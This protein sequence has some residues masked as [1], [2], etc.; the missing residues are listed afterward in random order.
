MQFEP[1]YKTIAACDNHFQRHV[2]AI[3]EF[4]DNSI[5]AC[6][7]LGIRQERTV[8]GEVQIALFLEPGHN[9]KRAFLVVADNGIGMNEG[10]IREFAKYANDHPVRGMNQVGRGAI[11]RFGVGATQASAYLGDRYR[12]VSKTLDDNNVYEF[13]SDAD[14]M[15]KKEEAK[16]SVYKNVISVREAGN[17][18]E[19]HKDEQEHEELQKFTDE[20]EIRNKNSFTYIIVRLRPDI[21]RQLMAGM[22]YND[23]PNELSEIYHFQLH[24]NHL[25]Q[26]IKFSAPKIIGESVNYR[27]VS[28]VIDIL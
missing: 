27:Y 7:N 6:S 22:R 9:D 12:L 5:Q 2:D 8:K 10:G 24:T 28:R 4:V 16:E 14:E 17:P 1:C 15:K 21:H 13:V 11:G 18:F 19:N 20:W 23:I 3:A 26:N 25:P